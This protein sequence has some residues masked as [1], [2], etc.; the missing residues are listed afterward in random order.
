ML[1]KPTIKWGVWSALGFLV[2]YAILFALRVVFPNSEPIHSV[3]VVTCTPVFLFWEA[4]GIHGE[5]AMAFGIPI[6]ISTFLFPVIVG[7]GVGALVHRIFVV[8]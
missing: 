7:F 6:I 3:L 4:I 1:T 8:R 5:A 2:V